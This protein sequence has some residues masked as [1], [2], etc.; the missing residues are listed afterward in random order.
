ME[1]FILLAHKR[2]L[3]V[4]PNKNSHILGDP[5]DSPTVG[6]SDHR[7]VGLKSCRSTTTHSYFSHSYTIMLPYSNI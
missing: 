5:I 7:S 1:N 3:A 6:L 4:T 2:Q